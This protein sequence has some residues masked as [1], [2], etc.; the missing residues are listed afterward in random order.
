MNTYHSPG[1]K[2][3]QADGIGQA[4]DLFADIIGGPD[5][6]AWRLVGV[7]ESICEITCEILKDGKPVRFTV[8]K[9]TKHAH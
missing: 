2:P 6:K 9:E 4:A 1:H 3:I 7:S 5:V 8:R